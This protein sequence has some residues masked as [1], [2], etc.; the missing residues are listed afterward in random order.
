VRRG[1]PARRHSAGG[2]GRRPTAVR[3]ARTRAWLGRLSSSGT[4]GCS[5]T[6]FGAQV[7]VTDAAGTLVAQESP[8][9]GTKT[10]EGYGSPF[11][12][13]GIA[14]GSNLC[15]VEVSHRGGLTQAEDEVRAGDLAFTLGD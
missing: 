8:R 14:S 1:R 9:F 15:T 12:V 13:D 11:T 6:D 5:D 3:Q 10:E 7:S 4:D 2:A